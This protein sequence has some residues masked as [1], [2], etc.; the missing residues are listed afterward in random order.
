VTFLPPR[1]RA[2]GNTMLKFALPIAAALA[3][4]ACSGPEE[5]AG[6]K[7]ADAVKAQAEAQSDA[8]EAQAKVAPTAAEKNALNKQADAVE[9][10]GEAQHDA[11]EKQID[12]DH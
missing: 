12:K 9:D 11:I 7:Q 6:H 1:H 5:D 4:A 8:L 10:G 2:E 3:L